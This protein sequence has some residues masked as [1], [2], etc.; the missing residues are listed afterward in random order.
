MTD[1][2]ILKE[3]VVV[4]T[5]TLSILFV[6]QKLGV[7]SIVGFLLAGVLIGPN[8][9]QI[10]R[11]VQEVGVLAN[12]G[13]VLLLFT[14]GLDLSLEQIASVRSYVIWAGLL[15][16]L[17][18]VLIVSSLSWS[19]GASIEVSLFYGFL[20]FNSSTALI[21]KILGD[22]GE[23]QALH[24]RVATGMLVIQDLAIVP[25][26]LLIPAIGLAGQLSFSHLGWALAQALLALLIIVLAARMGFPW[27]VKHVVLLRSRELFTLF[28]ILVS[29][30]TAWV[31]SAFGLSLAIGAF[32]AGLLIS[33]SEYS[34]QMASSLLT[35][36]DCFIGIFFISVGMLL[37]LDF[38]LGHTFAVI[39]GLVAML[40]VKLGV[41]I[42]IFWLLYRSLRLGLL[43]GLSFAQMGELNFVLA[44]AGR[45]YGLLTPA[46]EQMFLATSIL[47]MMAVPFLVQ[48]SRGLGVRLQ[49]ALSTAAF[50]ESSPLQENQL[51][52]RGHVIVL[53]YGLNGQNLCRV[54]KEVGIPYRVLDM[55]PQMVQQGQMA[56]EP[57]SFG[58]G[59]V[60]DALEKAGLE[61]AQVLV[62]AISDATAT[63][64]IVSQARR[65][66]PELHMIVR[67]R[68][69][70]E[71]ERLYRLG[72]NQVI[73]EEFETSVEI[74]ARVLQEYHVPRN[75]IALQVDLIRREHYGTL[76]GLRLQGKRLDELS[77]FLA[78]TTT[79]IFSI[80]ENSP[81][82][83]KS[84]REIDL[85]ARAG[86]TLIAVVRDGQSYQN[87]APDFRLAAG[88]RLVLLGNHKAL[89]DAAQLLNPPAVPGDS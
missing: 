62:V 68:Y 89:D 14:I 42:L 18:T 22:R 3:L 8:G 1:V 49:S 23:T 35:L 20:V 44:Q 55:D 63:A 29:L 78:G 31:A 5:A 15:Q 69:V 40:V 37:N 11:D 57:I 13:V 88:D 32:V 39:A 75:V 7:P 4:L 51:F 84:L 54:L 77:R 2:P 6:C 80:V 36:R 34:H 81:A 82:V 33:E 38:V 70:A 16:V 56:G 72:V 9:F 67:T 26:M 76:R 46:A 87:P 19:L 47:S 43:I 12:I 10:I 25:M 17:L 52:A 73:P 79:D 53:G 71:I 28:I 30:G 45:D 61:N 66:R 58:D 50:A 27:V 60:A 64:R 59:T 74:F 41:V 83:D 86:A 24:G 21:L 48:G 85:R 65:L